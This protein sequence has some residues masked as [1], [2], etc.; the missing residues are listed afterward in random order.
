[1]DQEVIKFFNE[2]RSLL[3]APAGFGKTTLLADALQYL[4]PLV[5]SP[6]LVLTHTHA[7]VSSIKKKCASKGLGSKVEIT[8]I[9]G[10]CQKIVFAFDG[11]LPKAKIDGRPNFNE[12][13][14]RGYEIMRLKKTRLIL[15]K[16]YSHVIADEHQDCSYLQHAFICLCASKIP[17]HIMADPLQSIFGF[18]KE[19]MVDFHTDFT[20]FSLYYFLQTPW[21]WYQDGNNR[22]L[23]NSLNL[24]RTKLQNSVPIKF[25]EID[26][27]LYLNG[28]SSDKDYWINLRKQ[29]SLMSSN[30][31]LILF[32]NGF[33]YQ[34]DTRAQKKTQ[35]DLSHQF[36]LLESID[37]KDFYKCAKILDKCLS[38]SEIEDFYKNLTDLLHLLS[39]KSRDIDDWFGKKGIKNKR[40][41][42]QK[43]KTQTIE[44]IISNI[45]ANNNPISGVERLLKYLRYDLGFFPKRYELLSATLAILK[46]RSGATMYEKMIAHR[47]RIRVVG[48][49]V[50]GKCI[51]TTLLTKGLEFDDVIIIDAHKIK[52]ANNLYVALTRAAK[53]LLIYSD[54]YIW[55]SMQ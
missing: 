37:D 46:N 29:I 20:K 45:V 11:H 3:I 48:R 23:G 24:L 10:F 33:E 27:A 26:G 51:G 53:R 55:N 52:D 7:G 13:L 47:N 2:K 30:S 9:S 54:S 35:F 19:R 34:I 43:N 1:M 12:I 6:I 17:L 40:N 14:K 31:L 41:I 18:N 5:H 50:E 49:K 36:T 4:C 39:F 8:T 28:D 16:S 22:R 15:S 32:P 21:R 42:I 25:N 44:T 38:S